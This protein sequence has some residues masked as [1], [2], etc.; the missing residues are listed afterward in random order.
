M[1]T[2]VRSNLRYADSLGIRGAR[3][4]LLELEKQVL[5]GK[6]INSSQLNLVQEQAKLVD[7]LLTRSTTVSQKERLEEHLQNASDDSIRLELIERELAR[8]SQH[9]KRPMFIALSSRSSRD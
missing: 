8:T 2:E 9:F 7:L 3:N 5:L 6:A 4:F 1:L